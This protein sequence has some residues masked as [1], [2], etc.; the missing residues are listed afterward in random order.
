MWPAFSQWH[1]VV[2][3]KREKRSL[4]FRSILGLFPV[5]LPI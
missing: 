5:V 2:E 1:L 3:S 4:L